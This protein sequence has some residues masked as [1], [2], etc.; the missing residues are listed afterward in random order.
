MRI[1]RAN[2]RSRAFLGV[3]LVNVQVIPV[4]QI[5]I[6]FFQTLVFHE[7]GA[8]VFRVFRRFSEGVDNLWIK[9]RFFETHFLIVSCLT[10]LKC[11]SEAFYDAKYPVQVLFGRCNL[12]SVVKGLKNFPR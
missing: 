4:S 5:G 3:F 6:L 10:P 11:A 8:T 1:R 12:I 2:T 7:F 9:L